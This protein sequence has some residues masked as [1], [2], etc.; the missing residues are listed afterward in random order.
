MSLIE[1]SKAGSIKEQFIPYWRILYGL[2]N[3][4]RY[5]DLICPDMY[6]DWPAQEQQDR[7]DAGSRLE[8]HA[9]REERGISSGNFDGRRAK[10]S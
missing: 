3:L 8:Q 4:Y 5:Y 1:N 6:P 7:Q 9:A 2:Y 10:S